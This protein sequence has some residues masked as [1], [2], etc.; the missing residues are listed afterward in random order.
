MP[1]LATPPPPERPLDRARALFGAATDRVGHLLGRVDRLVADARRDASAVAD[2]SAALLAAAT[3]LSAAVRD[4]VRATPR[5]ARIV[6][7]ALTL[8]ARYRVHRAR[9]EHLPPELAARRL[10]AL[11]AD[12]AERAARLCESLGGGVLKLGQTL[13]ARRDLLP[14]AWADA[15]ARLQ[16][17]VPPEPPE[18]IA[19]ALPAALGRPPGEAFA[20]FDPT[21]TAAGSLAQVHRATLADGRAVA[22]KIQRPGIGRLLEIDLAALR[23]VAHSLAEVFPIADPHALARELSRLVTDELDF[24]REARALAELAS[25]GRDAAHL[26][27]PAPL[28]ELS[29]E[30]VLAMEFIDGARLTDHLDAAAP[31]ARDALLAS[32]VRAFAHQIFVDGL[33]HADPHPGNLLV[34]ADE[35]GAPELVLIDLGSARRLDPSTRRGYAEL[36]GAVFS[37]QE[38][39]VVTL[40]RALGFD[41][42]GDEQ[43]LAEL[44]RELIR[45]VF[46][47]AALAELD[48]QA[49]LARALAALR[50]FPRV[51]VPDH[52]VAVGRVLGSLGGLILHYRPA[53]DL[54]RLVLPAVMAALATHPEPAEAAAPVAR[55]PDVDAT[56]ALGA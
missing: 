49:E 21:P 29:T 23:V 40:L 32:L 48:V 19:L 38:A 28:P 42:P 55:A 41:V 20:T 6:R 3:T 17:R 52:F 54:P 10:A 12:A 39:R 56:D 33:V 1:H 44:A 35:R 26:R 13:S 4:S 34:A 7:E 16:D 25:Y 53:L 8:L 43:A 36:L 15:L 46:Q 47:T 31:A 9:A 27:V 51:V 5:F 30:R 11:H 24:E 18:A 14:P 22:L 2:D 50:T 45:A 37:R